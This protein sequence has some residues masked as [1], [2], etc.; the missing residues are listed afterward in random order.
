MVAHNAAFD[1]EILRR[2]KIEVQNIID[3]YKIAQHLDSEAKVP[4]YNLQY[5]RYYFDL[6]VSDAPAHNALGDIR[7]LE[8]LFDHF[9]DQ[10]NAEKNDEK[11]VIKKMMEIS[12]K[13]I[14]IRKFNFGKYKDQLVG[15]VAL[16]DQGYLRWLL[17]EKIKDRE[18]R[19]EN[20]ENWI[21]TLEHYLK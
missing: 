16:S 3:T 5:L 8:R 12:A 18:E 20:D 7:V 17:G 15:E 14:F 21:Y 11:E 10:M 19:G 13:P 9:F 4:R 6:D 2:E 1:A